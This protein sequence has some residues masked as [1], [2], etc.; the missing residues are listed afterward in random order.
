VR[1]FD[2]TTGDTLEINLFDNNE[3]PV[4]YRDISGS[5]PKIVKE[6]IG[7]LSNLN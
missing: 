3:K 4:P 6:L 2:Q 7:T 5:N 1:R